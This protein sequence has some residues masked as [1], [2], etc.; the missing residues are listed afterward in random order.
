MKFFLNGFDCCFTA[1]E[2]QPGKGQD[3]VNQ[4]LQTLNLLVSKG[5]TP[6]R[7]SAPVT[8]VQ[9]VLDQAND[10]FDQF[11]AGGHPAPAAVPAAVRPA[12]AVASRSGP[13]VCPT[14]GK[15]D[16]VE[17]IHFTKD[18]QPKSAFKCQR[19]QKWQR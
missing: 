1:R 17:L 8:P 2:D 7:S 3:V 18:G 12:A 5:A 11:P 13:P 6:L 16:E 15:S 9:S 14:C 4:A 10:L 19:C